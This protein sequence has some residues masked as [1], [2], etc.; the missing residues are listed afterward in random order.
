MP[1]KG[2]AA[3][4]GDHRAASPAV[5]RALTILETLV[6]S[7]APMTL[8]ALAHAAGVPVATCASIMQTLEARGYTAR[9][10]V[11]RS[12]LW[13]A[14]LRLNGLSAELA[15]K[16][17]ISAIADP[18][19][20]QLVQSTGMAAHLGALEGATVIY[21]AKA[22]A[23]G[24][25]QFNTYPGKTAPFFQTALG[26]AIAAYLPD[27]RIAA[28]LKQVQPGTGPGGKRRSAAQ[29]RALLGEIRDRGYAV[30]DEEEDAN[31]G[32]VAAPYFDA[33]GQVIG[34]VGVTGFVD[35]V[36]GANLQPI[37]QAVLAQSR[38][39]SEELSGA[40]TEPAR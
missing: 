34:S 29:M 40:V 12:H 25:V 13:R 19:L 8:T 20:K 39:L 21:V 2:S 7:D 5:D 10:V 3:E 27:D 30:E 18:Y 35:R 9:R 32:C 22:S 17:D 26:R 15:R 11:G 28:L 31:I 16:L 36:R 37:A 33:L 6:A 1:N 4:S 24:M 14:T 38:A 23:P